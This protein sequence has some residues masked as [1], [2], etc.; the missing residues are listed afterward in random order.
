MELS[1]RTN[2]QKVLNQ[3]SNDPSTL[4]DFLEI[5][6]GARHIVILQDFP[7]PDAI[8]S[9]FV[10]KLIS[11]R[12]DIDVDIVYSGVISHQ[13][14]IAL[15]KL[16]G[17]E[18]VKYV[19]EIDLTQYDGVVFVDNQGTTAKDLV[20]ALEAAGVKFLILIDHHELQNV[21]QAE[22]SDIRP[23][24][25]T[26]TIYAQYMKDGLFE[27]DRSN[28]QHVLAATALMHGIMSDTGNFIQARDEDFQAASYL[29]HFADA[30][31]LKEIMSQSRSKQTMEVIHRA[32][33]NRMILQTFSISGVG[34]L[35]AEDRDAI[36]QAADFLLTEENVHTALVYGIVTDENHSEKLVGSFRT[37]KIT[38]DADG[39]MK[40]VFGKNEAG[41]YFGGGKEFAGGFVIP[42]GFLVGSFNEEYSNLKW[43]LY[44]QQ[45]KH[46]LLEKMGVKDSPVEGKSSS[47]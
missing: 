9:A 1:I 16:L 18:L 34:Y 39:F 4:G 7:D 5:H 2:G 19:P 41:E 47:S 46:L 37:T 35:R 8:S 11:S 33:A 27:L 29:S 20:S 40:E 24:G 43:Q 21:I 14:N 26:A 12:F 17:I 28:K 30:Q 25:A 38:M 10:H 22:Y 6:R 23:L 32:I 15:V 44:S 13:Q 42:I 36:P 45:V 3:N 31:T